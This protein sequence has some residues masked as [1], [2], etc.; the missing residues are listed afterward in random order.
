MPGSEPSTSQCHTEPRWCV[1][2]TTWFKTKWTILKIFTWTMICL[3]PLD[4][5]PESWK[6]TTIRESQGIARPTTTILDSSNQRKRSTT[7]EWCFSTRPGTRNASLKSWNTRKVLTFW[8]RKPPQNWIPRRQ[9]WALGNPNP[10][11]RQTKSCSSAW[12]SRT[13]K[14]RNT[15]S[16]TQR[17]ARHRKST[18]SWADPCTT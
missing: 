18:K 17:A 10:Q 14:L 16:L 1:H 12:F 4:P 5:N 3:E 8:K 6:S 9:R 13:A 7:R 2:R 15:V 11:F